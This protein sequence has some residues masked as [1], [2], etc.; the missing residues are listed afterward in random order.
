MI[1]DHPGDIDWALFRSLADLITGCAFVP[2]SI[3][4]N[5]GWDSTIGKVRYI[6]AILVIG[7]ADSVQSADPF[8]PIRTHSDPFDI[9]TSFCPTLSRLFAR[10]RWHSEY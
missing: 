2:T 3:V 6:L 8:G 7:F 5:V 4:V 10:T 9:L 1:E